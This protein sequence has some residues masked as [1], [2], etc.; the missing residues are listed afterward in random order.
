[1]TNLVSIVK[2]DSFSWNEDVIPWLLDHQRMFVVPALLYTFTV[3]Y[4]VA[5]RNDGWK[6][7]MF[8]WN[9]MQCLYS[10]YSLYRFLPSFA[11]YVWKYGY[12][13]SICMTN[14]EDSMFNQPYGKWV[15]LFLLS[16]IMDLGDTFFIM[17][18]GRQVPLIHW[19]HHLTTL[20]IG[21]L[22]YVR[23]VELIAWFSVVNMFIHTWMYGHYA[24]SSVTPIRGNKILTALQLVQLVH[25][26]GITVYH[27][28]FCR[29]VKDIEGLI[30]C[31]Q[32]TFLFASFFKT[33]YKKE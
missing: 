15:F 8:L 20:L 11:N 28:T 31:C 25:D 7:S 17:A 14:K 27:T 22:D 19:Y 21:Y 13:E 5:K 1:M 18:R 30:I 33:K 16:K 9:V 29:G 32:F 26:V 23:S 4:Q 10:G 12:H 6:K 3:Q 2:K 24:L